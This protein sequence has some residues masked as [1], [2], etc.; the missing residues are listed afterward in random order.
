[1]NNCSICL[2]EELSENDIYTTD[3]NHIFCN[4]CLDDW[5]KRGNESCPLCRSKIDIYIYKV[6]NYRLII[7]KVE[8]NNQIS[9]NDLMAHNA[10]VRNI[11]RKNIR[12]RFYS[13]SL[14]ILFLYIFNNYLYN[15]NDLNI[16]SNELNTCN[17]NTT[18][19]NDDLEQCNNLLYIN[20][21]GS[22]YYITMYNGMISRNCFYPVKLYNLCFS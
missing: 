6:E 21:I 7:H 13:F 22:G 8:R 2:K 16:I 17:L 3:C 10:I 5:F 19:L 14:T 1:M 11:V 20:N 9:L 4:K 18:K 15:L 12:L